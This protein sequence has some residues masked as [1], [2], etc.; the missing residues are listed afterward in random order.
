MATAAILAGGYGKRLRPLTHNTP[1]P[2]L[3]VGS[4]PILMW[5][6]EFLRR[7]GV[8]NF[9]LCVGYKK[10]NIKEALGDGSSLGVS[11]SY[12][13]EEEPLGTGGAIKNARRFLEGEEYFFVLN[14]DVLTDL[15]PTP[16]IRYVSER[17]LVGSIALVKL[18]SPYGIVY[19][20]EG[21]LIDRFV[22]KPLLPFWI[23]AGVYC[24]SP[25]VFDYLPDKGDL[26][27][28]TLPLLAEKKLLAAVRYK[29]VYWR[30]IDTHKDLDEARKE[31]DRLEKSLRS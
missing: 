30:S 12:A 9:V 25:E 21:D 31:I 13:E 8:D 24:F 10:E 18:P 15:D 11:I 23:N 26:E 5:Q 22:E 4:K 7:Y 3:T 14:G 6:I 28:T 19:V 16:L 20:G 17:G 29:D 27:R 2:L 1:K